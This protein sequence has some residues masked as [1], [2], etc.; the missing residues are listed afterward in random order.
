MLWCL[1]NDGC[2]DL[3]K[4]TVFQPFMGIKN[5]KATDTIVSIALTAMVRVTGFEPAASWPPVKR[6]SNCATPGQLDYNNTRH[7]ENQA[8][9]MSFLY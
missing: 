1:K 5:V 6:A 4:N 7:I 9:Y 3:A 8:L 2:I